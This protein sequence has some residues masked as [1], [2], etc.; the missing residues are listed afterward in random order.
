MTSS[1]QAAWILQIV[2]TMGPKIV[3][4][5]ATDILYWGISAVSMSAMY[6]QNRT[7][8]GDKKGTSQ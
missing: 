5:A 8:M 2:C 1:S 7:V 3:D 4:R 6:F